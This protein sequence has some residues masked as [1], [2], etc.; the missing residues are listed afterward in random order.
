[1]LTLCTI[2]VVYQNCLQT[3]QVKLIGAFGGY[4]SFY[5]PILAQQHHLVVRGSLYIIKSILT[6][7]NEYPKRNEGEKARSISFAGRKT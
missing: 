7:L 2:Y 6:Q 1:M 3:A 5:C 4:L